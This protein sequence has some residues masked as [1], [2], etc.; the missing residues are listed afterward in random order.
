VNMYLFFLCRYLT[1]VDSRYRRTIRRSHCHRAKEGLLWCTYRHFGFQ[2][3]IS[4][5]Y[6]G[7]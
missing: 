2:L 6:D 5:H 4:F 3:F 7:S 1:A